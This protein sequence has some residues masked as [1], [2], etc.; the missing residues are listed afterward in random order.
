V[1]RYEKPMPVLSKEVDEY[2]QK[3]AAHLN[4]MGFNF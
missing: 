2:E 4:K 1:D 3:V